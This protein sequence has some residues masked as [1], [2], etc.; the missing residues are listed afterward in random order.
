VN[1]T[2]PPEEAISFTA[3]GQRLPTR[4]SREKPAIMKTI[5]F[6]DPQIGGRFAFLANALSVCQVYCL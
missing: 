5:T 2:F 4:M 3:T 6:A 1:F